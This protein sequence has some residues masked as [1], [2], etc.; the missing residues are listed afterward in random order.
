MDKNPDTVV[1]VL[2]DLLKEKKTI[3]DYRTIVMLKTIGPGAKSAIP[4]VTEWLQ[5]PRQKSSHATNAAIQALQRM[6]S[7][8]P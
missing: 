4:A 5:G 7:A 2:I 8:N 1:P 3:F 6:G